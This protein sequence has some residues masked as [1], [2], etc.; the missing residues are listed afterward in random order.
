MSRSGGAR[1]DFGGRVAVVTGGLGG[2]GQAIAQ[3]LLASGASVALWDVR[4]GAI[5][6]DGFEAG[7]HA[8]ADATDLPATLS[9]QRDRIS[10]HVV[11]V[12]DEARVAAAAIE[13]LERFGH[14]DTLI[15]NAGILGPVTDTWEHTTEQFRRVLDVNLTG[16]F[17]CTRVVVPMLLRNP[18]GPW[19]GRIVNMASVQGK[20]GMPQAAAYAASKAGLMALTKTLGKELAET[21]I[22]ANV[23]T[24]AA[25]LTEMSK[26][27]TQ[28]RKDAILSR[29]PMGRFL[30]AEE[31]AAQ[32]AWLCSAECSFA[33]GAVFDLSGGRATY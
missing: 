10:L 9:A 25:V 2:L 18:P 14:I 32:V 15:N 17:I 12:T 1:F 13:T 5:P 27:I 6:E 20:E 16:A 11:D 4:T 29:I 8:G 7:V 21:G 19:R 3:R 26:E 22:L 30:S 31:V 28:A 33:T 24:P 23:V